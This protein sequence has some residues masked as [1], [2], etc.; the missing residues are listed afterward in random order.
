M[1][2]SRPWCSRPWPTRP[3]LS[4][5]DHGN[6]SEQAGKKF[7]RGILLYTGSTSVAFGPN[8]HAVRVSA[9]WQLESATESPSA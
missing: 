4:C 2:I 6:L 9:L 8:L 3:W 7:L 5:S 1:A